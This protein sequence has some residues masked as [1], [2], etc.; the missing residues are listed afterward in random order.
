MS[1]V[2]QILG[3]QP[4][5]HPLRDAFL[6]WQ[7]RVRMMSMRENMGKPDDPIMPSLT[8][9][10]DTEPMGH[11]I[12]VM[13]KLPQY[14]KTPEMQHMVKRTFD[15][16][17]RRTKAL[18]FFSETYYQKSK[19]FSDILT[20][21]FPVNSQ[22]AKAIRDAEKCKL[23]FEAYSQVFELECKVWTLAKTNALYQATWWHNHLF[24]PDMQDDA[25]ILGFEPDWEKSHAD[26][27][28]I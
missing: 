23:K 4:E 22:G 17:Q 18:E 21:S 14:G 28:P 19:E 24:N 25:V 16:A 13:S 6:R 1:S 15:P 5:P 11:V 26:P 20:S 2:A 12:T 3:F 10:G 7:C 9:Q 27:S 8:L